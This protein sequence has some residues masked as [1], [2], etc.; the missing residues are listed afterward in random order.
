M[1][2]FRPKRFRAAGRSRSP[3]PRRRRLQRLRIHGEKGGSS[4]ASVPGGAVHRFANPFIGPAATEVAV[5][6]LRDLI[7]RRVR[8]LRQQRC[9]GHDLS[10]L[11]VAA[12]RNL[13]R[14]PGLL[15]HV[16]AISS[17][18][19][20]CEHAFARDLRYR[21]RAGA[22]RVAI[23]V[24]RAGAA[25]SRAASEFRSGKFVGVAENPQEWGFRRDADFFFTAVDAECDVGHGYPVVE[26]GNCT[27]WYSTCGKRG[28]AEGW[29]YRARPSGKV[30]MA[31]TISG[32]DW[33]PGPAHFSLTSVLTV[34]GW[35]AVRLRRPDFPSSPA[36]R[37]AWHRAAGWN[38]GR[39]RPTATEPQLC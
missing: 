13:F 31:G 30:E 25:Q 18:A 37:C 3:G 39:V 2:S 34:S 26:F 15:Q 7:V 35:R 8:R 24:N 29:D 17:K 6:R 5:H 20:N 36:R 19:F 12:L 14:N 21:S 1:I 16:Q 38:S 23:D 27:T 9:G 22:N 11:A 32:W 33:P 4:R 10:R 28:M